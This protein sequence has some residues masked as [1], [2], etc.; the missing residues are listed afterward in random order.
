MPTL[1]PLLLAILLGALAPG[2]GV[3]QAVPQDDAG[4]GGDAPGGPAGALPV[5]PDVDHEGRLAG[6]LGD[7]EDWYAFEASEGQRMNV[8][9]HGHWACV[10]LF[11]PGDATRF[12]GGH[13]CRLTFYGDAGFI[14]RLDRDGAWAFR[15]RLLDDH[16]REDL[17]VGVATYRFRFSL[18]HR[19]LPFYDRYPAE[20]KALS[21][22]GQDDAESGRD[23]PDQPFGDGVLALP[24]DGS[25]VRGRLLGLNSPDGSDWYAFDVA[26][27]GRLR[28][29]LLNVWGDGCVGVYTP[30]ALSSRSWCGQVLPWDLP[31]FEL[32]HEGR[33]FIRVSMVNAGVYTLRPVL[34]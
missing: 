2:A 18:D 6:A 33:W 1:R 12:A 4:S 16:E 5:L 13:N 24:V 7:A 26:A 29:E 25:Y 19:T 23:A 30:D 20:V 31:V 28:F 3:A 11:G 34:E 14:A 21:D 8:A 15:I 27:P 10:E 22:E 17:G 9:L 32:P